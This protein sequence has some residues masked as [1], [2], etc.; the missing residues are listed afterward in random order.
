MPLA[1][2]DEHEIVC[3]ALRGMKIANA[4][5]N[6]RATINVLYAEHLVLPEF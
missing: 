3:A 4:A 6:H 5:T 2:S 1:S